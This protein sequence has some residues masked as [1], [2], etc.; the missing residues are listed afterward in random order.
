MPEIA[1]VNK[2]LL[3]ELTHH[4]TDSLALIKKYDTLEHIDKYLTSNAD[5]FEEKVI[6]QH[7]THT[8]T[9]NIYVLQ[10]E[11]KGELKCRQ[12]N[13][14]QLL[15][16]REVAMNGSRFIRLYY[17]RDWKSEEDYLDWKKQTGR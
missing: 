7:N 12:G 2:D 1:F 3:R 10:S 15:F 5:I 11:Y 6:H 17:I 13:I 4:E 16:R 14:V 8:R 9:T